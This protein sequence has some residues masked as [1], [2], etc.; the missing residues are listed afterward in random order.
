MALCGP[1]DSLVQ[2]VVLVQ[3]SMSA[4][5]TAATIKSA[6]QHPD[7]FVFGELLVLPNVQAVRLDSFHPFRIDFGFSIYGGAVGTYRASLDPEIAENLC[8]WHVLGLH[9][10]MSS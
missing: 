9:S 8:V 3:G 1:S 10:S 6:I 2:F 7:V 4:A 5:S